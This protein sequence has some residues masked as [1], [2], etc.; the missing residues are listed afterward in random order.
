MDGAMLTL[1]H[2]LNLALCR[3]I[4]VFDQNVKA[5]LNRSMQKEILRA[6]QMCNTIAINA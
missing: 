1:G 6:N 2:G 3:F 5:K 4:K